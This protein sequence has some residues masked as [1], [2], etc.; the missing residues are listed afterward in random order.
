[1]SFESSPTTVRAPRPI[2]ATVIS[3]WEV[4][5]VVL[6]VVS[7]VAIRLLHRSHQS[8]HRSTPAVLSSPLHMA[9]V[10]L[11]AVLGI[12]GAIA[13]WQM[14]RV[15]FILLAA[16]FTVELAMFIATLVHPS[17]TRTRDSLIPVFAFAISIT[18]L[19]LNAAIAWYTF[20]VTTPKLMLENKP[21]PTFPAAEP[22]LTT[23]QFY[24]SRDHKETI[25]KD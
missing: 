6:A 19:V 1:M 15:A 9:L 22:E 7:R 23:A 10:V 25:Y 24:I 4:L 13:L 5:I 21:E 20:Y 18:A 8:I 11:A 12:A 16:R 3:V 2:L 17:I 14:R